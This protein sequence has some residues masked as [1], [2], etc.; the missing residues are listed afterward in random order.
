MFRETLLESSPTA[1]RN[2]RWPMA[3]AFTIE[4][5]VAGVVI[6]VPLLSTGVLPVLARAASPIFTPLKPVEIERVRPMSATSSLPTAG[7]S[8]TMA[9]TLLASNP[10]QIHWGDP[11]PTTDTP[12]ALNVPGGSSNSPIDDVIPKGGGSKDG[13]RGPREE[14]TSRVSVVS[15]LE[16]ARLVNRVEPIYPKIAI[17][18]GIRGEVKLHAIIARDGSI[19][20]LNVTSGHPVLAAA[21]VDAVRQ[22]RYQP[23]ILN[24]N[25]VEV[26]TLITV[27][28]R[29]SGD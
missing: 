7:G 10:N 18:S 29:R 12:T 8:R 3:T 21:A 4:L 20:S 28:F 16:E 9:V 5:I 15:R 1:R 22:W 23:Y 27:N 2:K 13:P 6:M 11:Q 25:P 19:Q 14:G 26:D 24:G 17:I